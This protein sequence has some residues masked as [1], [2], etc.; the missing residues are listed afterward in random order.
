M[1]SI[2]FKRIILARSAEEKSPHPTHKVGTLL[3]TL[4]STSQYHEQQCYNYW[5]E[6]LANIIELSNKLGNASTTVHAEISAL[7]QAQNST[8]KADTY[9]TDLP[10]PNCAKTLVEAGIANIYIDSA[11]H[12]TPLG[13]KMKPFFKDVSLLIFE[14]AGTGVHEVNLANQ[15][16]TTLSK[17]RSRDNKLIF[18]KAYLHSISEISQD[19]F[20][21]QIKMLDYK[22]NQPFAACIAQD[23]LGGNYFLN[24]DSHIA[25]GLTQDDVQHIS[26]VQEK[27]EPTL[28][29]FNRLL[30][31]CAYY[32]LKIQDGYLFADQCPTAREFVNMIGYGLTSIIIS[33]PDQCR[34]IWGLIALKQLR[35]HNVME[36]T[37]GTF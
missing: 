5:P 17:P 29:P 7:I 18:D 8:N 9:V 13:I 36:I 20:L 15:S 34:D 3:C 14:R 30:A 10:C 33:N 25:L 11:T 21:E 23:H 6:P 2:H 32:N 1:K 37:E 12:S 26:I 16:I 24:A 4:S 31:H 22:G 28:Q 27:Y 35:E 19:Q